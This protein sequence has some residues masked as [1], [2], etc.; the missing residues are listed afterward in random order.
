MKKT[1]FKSIR[2][3]II[4][5]Y[6]LILASTLIVLNVMLY[7]DYRDTLQTELDNKLQLK[8]E[9]L[10]EA[11]HTY[12]QTQKLEMTKEWTNTH[13]F[14]KKKDDTF[15]Q[16][17][18]Q[19]TMEK[20]RNG[21]DIPAVSLIYDHK[22]RLIASSQ[23]IEN[24]AVLNK[25]I[26]L[27]IAQKRNRFDTIDLNILK[28]TL[29]ARVISVPII[30]GKQIKYVVQVVA[31]LAPL[32]KELK[33]LRKGFFVQLPI[34]LFIAIAGALVLVEVTLNPVDEM[35]K[36][37]RQ[38]NPD[39]LKLRIKVPKTGDEI[40]RLAETFNGMLDELEK[41]FAAQ[42]QIVQDISHE[43]RTP[44]TILQG[45]QEVALRR[46]RSIVDYKNTLYSNLEEISKMKRIVNNLLLLAKFDKESVIKDM[47]TVELTR[48]VK[49]TLE[50]MKIL[51][52]AKNI[53]IKFVE[54]KEH[55]CVRG[56]ETYLKLLLINLIDNAIKF[57]PEGGKVCIRLNGTLSSVQIDVTDTGVGIA[58]K[59][60]ALIFNRFYRADKTRG[61][62]EGFGLGLS[63]AR[64][65][66]N[67]HRGSITVSSRFNHGSTFMVHLPLYTYSPGS[68]FN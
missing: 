9:G 15:V 51:A 32:S 18:N 60:L 29:P 39:S 19:L 42:R 47:R 49:E 33:Q 22:G 64:S 62:G 21:E 50:E 4:L 66:V 37:I 67:L 1:F 52:Q 35:V 41:S 20:I 43:L 63:I 26:L 65:V 10:D 28:G 2:F 53:E 57:T 48:L 31:S 24:V 34:V 44:L 40:E 3:Q 56:E 17:A 25:S 14:Y 46:E 45:Q 61:S 5:L 36:S 13:I 30:E 16:I 27:S 59:D 7:S 68:P 38:I 12:W 23:E 54:P 8:A 55:P 58:E 6:L 11:I